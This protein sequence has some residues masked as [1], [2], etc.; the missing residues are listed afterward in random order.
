MLNK[1]LS[2]VQNCTSDRHLFKVR[3]REKPLR[4]LYADCNPLIA[5]RRGFL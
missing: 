4:G 5:L 2:L 3:C 1:C